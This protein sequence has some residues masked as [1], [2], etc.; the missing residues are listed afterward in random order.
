MMRMMMMAIA[1][2]IL[3]IFCPGCASTSA[4]A[5]PSVPLNVQYYTTDVPRCP[6]EV[7]GPLFVE[8]QGSVAD[9]THGNKTWYE[10]R[11][12]KEILIHGGS[13]VIEF[14]VNEAAMDQIL[15]TGRVIRFKDPDCLH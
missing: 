11:L 12:E 10:E 4:D 8:I 1:P 6:F 3:F 2:C 5:P 14:E 15:F 7:V 13:A 9:Y